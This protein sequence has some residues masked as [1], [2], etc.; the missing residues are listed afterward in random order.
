MALDYT[1]STDAFADIVEGTY[2]SS[3]YPAM[4]SFVTAASRLIDREFGR[5]PG[6]FYPSTDDQTF[7]Y[8]GSGESE[9]RIDEFVS[10]TSVSMSEQGLIASTDYTAWILNTDYMVWPYNYAALG[11]PIT[12]L[13]IAPVVSGKSAFYGYYKGLKVVGVPG[14]SAT[15]P[16]VI[17]QAC[18]M[19]AIRWF[20][21]AKAGYQDQGGNAEIGGLKF[22]VQNE[23]DPEIKKLLHG[24]KLELSN[25]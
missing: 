14:Y 17:V 23:L 6:F 11:V 1:T 25:G 9:Q 12:K 20:M 19:Q 4:A 18:K 13:I 8:D 24:L 16:D 3:D 15:P 10:I 5:W 7:Y 2:T 22:T 21:Q